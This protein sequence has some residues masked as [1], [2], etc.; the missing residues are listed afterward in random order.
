MN[1][2]LIEMA[3][4]EDA[5]IFHVSSFEITSCPQISLNE[6]KERSFHVIKAE[7]DDWSFP[8]DRWDFV[9]SVR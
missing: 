4:E 6:I 5:K 9:E 3:A 1:N 2:A 7:A 8:F